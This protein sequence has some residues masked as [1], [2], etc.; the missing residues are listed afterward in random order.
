MKRLALTTLFLL[1]LSPLAAWCAEP[2]S[3]R[4]AAVELLKV[5]NME[6]A[7]IAGA[8]SML[9][10]QAQSNPGFA[11]YRDVVQKWVEKYLTWDAVGPR[12]TD[13]YE[14]AF[15]EPEIR[16]LIAFYK[17]PTGQKALAKMPVLMQQG[18]QIGMEVTQQH[19]AE[20]EALIHARG[21]ELEKAR[22][23]PDGGGGD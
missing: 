7:M 4:Q 16:D 15:T 11:P 5:M 10:A 13:L 21:E 14:A 17:T 2:D 9:D 8:S 12:M 20:L 19:K 6:N 3:H 1:C 18:M 23:K 22:K